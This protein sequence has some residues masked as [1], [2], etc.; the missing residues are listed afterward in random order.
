MLLLASIWMKE[1]SALVETVCDISL[2]SFINCL[3]LQERG[4]NS[5][6]DGQAR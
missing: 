3:Y 1:S 6:H 5:E 2:V 4:A